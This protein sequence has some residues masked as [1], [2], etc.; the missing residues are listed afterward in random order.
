MSGPARK[1]E[2]AAPERLAGISGRAA[3]SSQEQDEAGSMAPQQPIA[4]QVLALQ[5]LAGNSAV[6]ALL[7]SGSPPAR[8]L[9]RIPPQPSPEAQKALREAEEA[10][11]AALEAKSAAV[12]AEIQADEAKKSAALAQQMA[13]EAKK[14]LLVESERMEL[15]SKIRLRLAL[16]YTAFVS[17]SK[18]VKDSLRSAAKADAEMAGMWVEIFVGL[19]APGL[20]KGLAR[21]ANTIPVASSNTAY[22]AAFAALN[23]DVTKEMFK[24]AAKVGSKA[25]KDNSIALFGEVEDEQFV[26]RLEVSTQKAVDAISADLDK[27]SDLELGAI[28]TTYDPDNANVEVYRKKIKELITAYKTEVKV[29]LDRVRLVRIDAYGQKRLAIIRGWTR[30]MQSGWSLWAWVS[31][32][33]QTAVLK[34]F[35]DAKLPIIDDYDPKQLKG[36]LPDPDKEIEWGRGGDILELVIRGNPNPKP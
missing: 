9:Q 34:K 22:R 4:R 11:Q 8:M 36:H 3:L 17:A 32:E 16:A 14:M 24:S 15:R 12:R 13:E 28:Y 1:R 2:T 6:T 10:K 20:A 26:T 5:R 29:P 18:D 23:T 27:K 30:N 33:M 19:L 31:P 25:L 35:E 21:Y 7:R